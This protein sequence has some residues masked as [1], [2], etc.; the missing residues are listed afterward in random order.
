MAA[1]QVK[2]LRF[3]YPGSDFLLEIPNLTI[4][5][6]EKVAMIGPSGFGKT[7]F[8]NLISGISQPKT[9]K[10]LI[11]NKDIS[12][13]SDREKRAFR[14]KEIGFVFQDF[15]LI[16]YLP[17]IQNILL[18]FRLNKSLNK[19]QGIKERARSLANEL[20]I[21]DKLAKYPHQLSHGEKQRAAIARA[22]IHEP[23][24]ILAD[25]PT[26]NLDPENKKKIKNLLFKLAEAKKA[27]L[28]MVTHDLELLKG[29]DR[30][31]DL[32]NLQNR[33]ENEG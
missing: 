32:S 13:L 33:Y 10:I 8:L 11:G 2:D 20:G 5:E 17:I 15:K 6:M 28:L 21:E 7:T 29:F 24:L 14:I 27:T 9:G 12:A 30:T 31:I 22:L 4:Q 1:I 19:T 23:I 25:E 18:P 16:E 3:A 26:G